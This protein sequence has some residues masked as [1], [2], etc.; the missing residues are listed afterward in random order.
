MSII[1]SLREKGAWIMTAVIA[2]ALLV[3]V[4]EEGLR[5]K[6][7]FGD[8]S[9]TLGKVNGTTIDRI[10]FEERLKRIEDRYT[11]MGYNMD[12]NSRMQE[13]N[14][15]W[16]EYVDDAVLNDEYEKLGIEVT[17][18]ELGDYLY[19][20]NPPQDF[21]QQFTDPNTGQFDAIQAHQYVQQL[22]KQSATNPQRALLFDEY[23]PAIVKF[24]MREKLEAMMTNSVYVPK[25]L[26]EKTSAENSQIASFSYVR[27]PYTSIPDS[28]IKVSDADVNEFVAKNKTLFKQEKAAG[29]DYV[30]F[31][32]APSK[33]DSNAVV[34]SLENL[35]DSF[36]HTN[37]VAQLLLTEGTI[38]PYFNS[39]LTRKEIKIASID[40]IINK[41][42]GTAYGPYMDAG[43]YV[44][45][46]VVDIKLIPEMVKVR[47]ILVATMQ[48]TQT[49]QMVPVRE[50]TIAKNLIDS[51]VNAIKTGSNFDTLCLKFSDDGTKTTGGIY[52]SIV[53]GKMVVAFND[54]IFTNPIGSKGVVKTEFGYH[55][56]EILANRGPIVP[57]YK[58]A[59][60]SKPI[61]PSDETDN[62]AR[63]AANQFAAESRNKK[64]FEENAKK[65]N[66]EVFNA[67]EIK[68]LDPSIRGVG[69]DGGSSRE[70][71]RWIFNEAELGDVS[72][73]PFQIKSSNYFVYVVPVVTH[74][75]EEGTQGV[76][77]AR[78]TS[79]AKIRQQKKA[80]MIGEKI[81]SATTLEAVSK[82]TNEPIAKADSV[83]FSS[84]QSVIGYEP[85]LSGA[86][87]NKSY[88]SKISPVI[89]GEV[90]IF[91]IKTE[92]VG[93]I[94]NPNLDV[95]SQQAAQQQQMR[96]F[97]QRSIV[98]NLKKS[99]SIKDNRY[100]HF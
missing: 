23:F 54:Y 55:Y 66:L 18:K 100:K 52:D 91:V 14:R 67:A 8:S 46:R 68:P 70:M 5:N 31:N 58:V 7:M 16:N 12:D 3:F 36:A 33:A 85:K 28:T 27:V 42:A 65:K 39:Y 34:Q 21:K 17:E 61:L 78:Q 53:T 47:H 32:A 15:L 11:Q 10:K 96:M 76:E 90:G 24:R 35:K 49:G 25:W 19:G 86:A 51:I 26:I 22:K 71:I 72:E 81:A 29:I 6:T 20:D 2:F 64:Q 62:N 89:A 60:L 4:V 56:I 97:N 80:K 84:P 83:S 92:S 38:T 41:P 44:L 73:R 13:R 79:E 57:G 45:G 74:L 30:Y 48:Q 93:A 59:Y 69:I 63:G 9:N 1:Q 77:R 88:Q 99:A 50:E 82:A 43:T 95:K 75:Y 37:D 98:E 40:S 94:P 87:F